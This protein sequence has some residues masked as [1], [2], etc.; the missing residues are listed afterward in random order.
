MRGRSNMKRNPT[1]PGVIPWWTTNGRFTPDEA[2]RQLDDFLE[3]GVSEFMIYPNFGLEYPNFLS[4]AWFDF[5]R[6]VIEACKVRN[7]HFWIYDDL[8]WPS[9]TAGGVLCKEHPEYLMHTLRHSRITLA[10]GEVWNPEPDTEYVRLE[11]VPGGQVDVNAVENAGFCNRTQEPV[12]LSV[13][14][15]VLID[16]FFLSSMGTGS[17]ENQ[18]GIMDALNPE[19][20]RCWM[21]YTYV[22]YAQRFPKDVGKT[23]RGFF[24]DEPTMISPFYTC[25]IP[26]TPGLDKLF[27]ETYHYDMLPHLRA[28]FEQL[29]HEEQ[30]RL[31]F[32]SL[33]ANRFAASF[34]GQL[35]AWCEQYGLLLSGHCWPEEPSCQRLMTVETGDTHLLQKFLHVPGTDVLYAENC[36]ADKAGMCPNTEQ[37]ARNL[38]YSAKQ[39]SSTARYSGARY[40][41]CET[42]GIAALGSTPVSPVYQKIS[43]DFLAAMGI[44]VMNP[45]RPF[46]MTD[47]RKHICGLDAG[48]P[49]WKY[50]RSFAE[51]LNLLASFNSR[52]RTHT[53]LAVLD[54]L[55]VKFAYSEIAPDTSIRKEKTKLPCEG[56]CA[57]AMLA[58]LD[59]LV[60]SQRDFEL[61][62]EDVIADGNVS[63]DGKLI[64]PE[65][66]FDVVILPQCHILDAKVF[67]KLAAFAER[68]GTLIAVG[69]VPAYIMSP[70]GSGM[71]PV[72]ISMPAL[73]SQSTDFSIRLIHLL[74]KAAAPTYRL[75]GDGSHGVIAQLRSETES[76]WQALFLA[77]GTPGEKR[78]TLSGEAV[79]GFCSVTD[80]Q[81][82]KVYSWSVEDGIVL[83]EGDSLLLST[84]RAPFDVHPSFCNPG[85]RMTL[86][87]NGWNLSV[88][89]RN[90]MLLRLEVLHNGEYIPIADNGAGEITFDPEITPEIT[91][92]GTFSIAGR[93]PEDLRL[94]LDYVS[95]HDL[96]VN[97]HKAEGYRF[98]TIVDPRNKVVTIAPLCHIG[99]NT[100]RL[101]VSL[102]P[103][104]LN[105]YGIRKH[106][107][108]FMQGCEPPVLLGSFLTG[109]DHTIIPAAGTLSYG[110]LTSHGFSHF[111]DEVSVMQ[112]FDWDGERP[113][114][115]ILVGETYLPVSAELNGTDFGTRLWKNGGF[116]IRDG[117]LHIGQNRLTIR[118]CGDLWNLLE[119]RWI[120]APAQHTPF[121]FPKVDLIY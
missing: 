60:R 14:K 70:G 11:A 59:A 83:A 38:I 104:M 35:S 79:Q 50:Y 1:L 26:W 56:D 36:F 84:D 71:K 105:R 93:V 32:W 23:I 37:W 29:P 78:L 77:N 118:L 106:F 95:F 119:R 80:V 48:Q 18:T 45:A 109:T 22:P 91:L 108:S 54:P 86:P 64:V 114:R 2:E 100:L 92:R 44:S 66:A 16:D 39:P 107:S 15:K 53:K 65:S 98:E 89:I 110:D 113:Y 81:T 72:E 13:I 121:I 116:D 17:S 111:A 46:D 120:G 102:T 33:L 51:Y 49:Y 68:G 24:F 67:E 7:M 82:G 58:T 90:S 112:T 62:F 12:Q 8:N 5:I 4:E 115:Q 27:S 42:S 43:F 69:D 103:L 30:F 25:D 55:T 10:P 21:S 61:I 94:W 101:T 19:A 34:T 6:F 97:G 75:H 99:V 57:E 20:V 28:L 3:K 9:G 85:Q 41:I 40:T 63:E 96:E 88:P 117:L 76:G 52:G 74:D 73:D 87:A 47:F 31:D